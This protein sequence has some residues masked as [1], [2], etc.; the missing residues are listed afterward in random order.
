MSLSK[1]FMQQFV[2]TVSLFGAMVFAGS[3]VG[4]ILSN[5]PTRS[6]RMIQTCKN[7][8]FPRG[9]RIVTFYLYRV[10][11]GVYNILSYVRN[12]NS[13]VLSDEKI[14]ESFKDKYCAIITEHIVKI[15]KFEIGE[16]YDDL[17]IN[18]SSESL[19]KY[20]FSLITFDESSH[21]NILLHSQLIGSRQ[22]VSKSFTITLNGKEIGRCDNSF[23]TRHHVREEDI[24]YLVGQLSEKHIKI[25]C[26]VCMDAPQTHGFSHGEC[27]HK[28]LCKD[29]IKKLSTCP[30]CKQPGDPVQIISC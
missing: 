17:Q 23:I 18:I 6:G 21:F 2:G 9:K 24:D 13:P 16:M 7:T 1:Q 22:D 3:E 4:R 11:D 5:I 29:C 26:V 27:C 8:W 20:S 14:F 30:I 10:S 25:P 19:Q 15:C 12:E 28:A